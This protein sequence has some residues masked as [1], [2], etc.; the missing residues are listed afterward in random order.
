MCV[1]VYVCVVCR[2]DGEEG[3]ILWAIHF[4]FL[5]NENRPTVLELCLWLKLNGLAECLLGNKERIRTLKENYT[6]K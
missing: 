2:K 1:S 3:R 5:N 6:L 4:L